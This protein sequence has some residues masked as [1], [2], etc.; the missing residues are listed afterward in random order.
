MKEL[1]FKFCKDLRTWK[2][3]KV[4][5]SFSTNW[6][7]VPENLQD[8]EDLPL[9]I[10]EK[11]HEIIKYRRQYATVTHTFNDE[12]EEKDFFGLNGELR[13]QGIKLVDKRSTSI[14]QDKL[15][16]KKEKEKKTAIKKL[17]FNPL[18]NDSPEFCAE[19]MNLFKGE[20]AFSAKL[21]LSRFVNPD[22]EDYF[23]DLVK[24]DAI[25]LSQMCQKFISKY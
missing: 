25:S 12:E 5:E 7:F 21:E 24:D 9:Y 4:K 10:Q 18:I 16:K 8:I 23:N 14:S 6:L 2:L 17:K 13:I 1:H 3:I 20:D 11:L 15:D 19:F 22:D